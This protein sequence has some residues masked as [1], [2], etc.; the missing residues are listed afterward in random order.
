L[1]KLKN[2][3]DVEMINY[4][5]LIDYQNNTNTFS[6]SKI[7]PITPITPIITTVPTG[8]TITYGQQ[9]SSSSLTGGVA[10]NNNVTIPGIWTFTTPLIVPAVGDTVS[11]T[12]SPTDT[13]NYNIITTS[14]SITINK[15]IPIITTVPIATP[16]TYGQ[17]LSSSS[18]TGGVIAPNINNNVTIPGIW[19][20]TTPLS[21]PNVGTTVSVTFSP[22][23]TINYTTIIFNIDLIVVIPG[24]ISSLSLPTSI[25]LSST[26]NLNIYNLNKSITYNS[27][28]F[29]SSDNNIATI[30]SFGN[31][32]GKKAGK[33]YIIVTDMSGTIIYTTSYFIEIKN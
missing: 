10:T 29:Y 20:F 4:D 14:I 18:L 13:T 12:F 30:D 23:D 7:T 3:L 25:S 9:L 19:S 17:Q 26:K 22:T 8:I 27:Y 2:S 6:I 5:I 31:I 24:G 28:K 15:Y 11:V 16:I 1:P 21:I 33:F 32:I